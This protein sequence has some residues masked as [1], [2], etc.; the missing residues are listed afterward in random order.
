VEIT[1]TSNAFFVLLTLPQT[2]EGQNKNKKKLIQSQIVAMKRISTILNK[3]VNRVLGM[4]TKVNSQLKESQFEVTFDAD[5]QLYVIYMSIE[6]T[7]NAHDLFL[8]TFLWP[9]QIVDT[10]TMKECETSQIVFGERNNKVLV[11][12]MF[13][14]HLGYIL[15][16]MKELKEIQSRQLDEAH[17][18]QNHQNNPPPISYQFGEFG[19]LWGID[20]DG[21]C[22]HRVVAT[23]LF[24][25]WQNRSMLGSDFATDFEP[26][27]KMFTATTS[28]TLASDQHEAV[29]KLVTERLRKVFSEN[30]FVDF[31]NNRCMNKKEGKCSVNCD[32]PWVR[33]ERK[34]QCSYV[35]KCRSEE[36]ISE[37]VVSG[38]LA[39]LIRSLLEELGNGTSYKAMLRKIT[40]TDAKLKSYSGSS[41]VLMALEM[42][43]AYCN[44]LLVTVYVTKGNAGRIELPYTSQIDDGLSAFIVFENHGPS[45]PSNH[46]QL[47]VPTFPPKT[48]PLICIPR[49]LALKIMDSVRKPLHA[50][51]STVVDFGTSANG[52]ETQPARYTTSI[53]CAPQGQA[54]VLKVEVLDVLHPDLKKPHQVSEFDNRS[55]TSLTT[56]VLV[57]KP[58]DQI[59]VRRL[60]KEEESEVSL[61]LTLT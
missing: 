16:R 33:C 27:L 8:N 25:L 38:L 50:P 36:Q 6:A 42:L 4:A 12:S 9:S 31:V 44:C 19:V 46:Y 58:R 57:P 35:C 60:T 7:A 14:H 18:A 53:P 26:V 3:K 40:V 21:N 22:F 23:I 17:S 37:G 56:E 41:S 54:E 34:G 20:G 5:G 45:S 49:E 47:L 11:G 1:E 51:Q 15:K 29:R 48:D 61:T 28:I 39:D 13:E 43:K 32:C 2:L 30:T 55:V 52:T 10:I 59:N 24:S